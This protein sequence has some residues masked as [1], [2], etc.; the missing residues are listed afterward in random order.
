LRVAVAR[1]IMRRKE[2][3][4]RLYRVSRGGGEVEGFFLRFERTVSSSFI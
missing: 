1:T 3:G 4:E 2:G